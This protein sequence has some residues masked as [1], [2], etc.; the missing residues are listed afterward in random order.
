MEDI[1][2]FIDT[3]NLKK[4]TNEQNNSMKGK[5]TVAEATAYLKTLNNNKAPGRTGFTA[6]FYKFFWSRILHLITCA[7]NFCF[8]I[9]I[10]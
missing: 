1:D 7:I 2:N 3:R 9:K 8:Q 5:V 6:A 10:L 4:V